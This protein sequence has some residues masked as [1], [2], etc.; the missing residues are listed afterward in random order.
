MKRITSRQ[1]GFIASGLMLTL[2]LGGGGYALAEEHAAQQAKVP[3]VAGPG[4]WWGGP[5]ARQ[6]QPT[7][8]ALPTQ[9]TQSTQVSEPATAAEERGV[10]LVETV[11]GYEGAE[12]AGTGVVLTSNGYVLTNNHVVEGATQIRVVVAATG[13]SY[14]ARVVGTDSTGDVAVLRLEDA[15][16]LQTATI[17]NDGGA[18]V[19]DQ[20]TAVGNAGG[21][22]TLSAA[23]GTV[24][25]LEQ[26]ITTQSEGPAQG[27]TLSGLIEVNAD[28]VS[29]DSGGPLLDSEGEVVGIDTAASSGSA[30][31]TGYAVPIDDALR[32]AHAIMAGTASDTVTIGYPAFLGVQVASQYDRLGGAAIAGVIDGTPAQ[33]AGLTAGS[34]ITAVDGTAITSA[35]GLTAALAG[36]QPGDAITLTWTDAVGQQ[37]SARVVLAEGPAA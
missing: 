11:L 32:I 12:A 27:E 2:V 26:S 7:Q 15:S 18:T 25:A 29:G 4:T 31:I 10:V 33:Q 3:A 37:H 17:D 13:E 8:P 14:T 21:T 24:A 20:V 23:D 36:H 5:P 1:A 9:D 16:G 22:G 19:G 30:D 6:E 28:V 35:D 34:T